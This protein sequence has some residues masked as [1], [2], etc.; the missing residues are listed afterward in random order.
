M[1]TN[2][3]GK[4]VVYES[5]QGTES[6]YVTDA[7]W[8]EKHLK[9][10]HYPEYNNQEFLHEDEVAG[11]YPSTKEIPFGKVYEVNSI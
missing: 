1:P 7:L 2:Y 4:E 8:K 10:R 3:H 9:V 5:S 11:I 6:I